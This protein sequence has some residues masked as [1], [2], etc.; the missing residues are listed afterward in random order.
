MRKASKRTKTCNRNPKIY[1]SGPMS[2]YR[3]TD[4]NH[5]NFNHWEEV[6]KEMGF[7]VLNPAKHDPD[8]SKDWMT[9]I[10]NDLTWIKKEQPEYI[11]MLKDWQKSEGACIEHLVCLRIGCMPLYEV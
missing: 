5:G 4:W 8:T 11:F 6:F 10:I 2:L 9:Y 7:N 1:I 3:H